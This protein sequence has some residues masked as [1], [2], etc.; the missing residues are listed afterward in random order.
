VVVL[1]LAGL[2]PAA[3]QSAATVE[4]GGQMAR[5]YPAEAR[6]VAGGRVTWDWAGSNHSVTFRS[7]RPTEFADSGVHTAPYQ[8]SGTFPNPGTYDYFCTTHE[9]IGMTGRVVVTGSASPAPTSS[10]PRPTTSRPTSA[11]ATTAPPTTPAPEPTTVPPTT[12]RPTTKPPTV[13][14]TPAPTPTPSPS[15]T[16]ITTLPPLVLEGEDAGTDRTGLA[17]AL[18]ALVS[19]AGFAAAAWAFVRGRR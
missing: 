3:A 2:G 11:P 16:V 13:S 17:L 14:A 7:A 19:G 9:N 18:G 6:I 1:S 4:V 12:D 10:P 15:P 8:V 5:Y